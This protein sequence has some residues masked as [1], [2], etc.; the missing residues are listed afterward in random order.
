MTNA[1]GRLHTV[2]PKQRECFFLRL[3]LVNFPGSFQYLRKF[4]GTLYDTFF[5][6]CRELHLLEDDNHWDLT[7]SDAAL[8]SS[9]HQICQ[10]FSII[11]T[12]GFP[13][14]AS[15]LWNKYKDS[16]SENIL[17]RIRITTQNHNIE[18]SAEIYGINN[19]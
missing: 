7:L 11:L 1:L 14:E 15:G 12:T 4:N 8:S 10:L 13:T 2:H 18:F 19:D 9:L 16:M 6:A 17:H 3:L 5:D